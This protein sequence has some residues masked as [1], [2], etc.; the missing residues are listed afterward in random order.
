MQKDPFQKAENITEFFFFSPELI[1]YIS[2]CS[3][4]EFSEDDLYI[5]HVITV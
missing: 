3:N 5:F 2:L 1:S 4:M